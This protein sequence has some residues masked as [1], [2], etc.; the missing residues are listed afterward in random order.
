MGSFQVGTLLMT[1]EI[2]FGA[3]YDRFVP[4]SIRKES[5]LRFE[6]LG[7]GTMTV[8]E[9]EVCFCQLAQHTTIFIPTNVER[10]CQ[11][12]RGLAYSIR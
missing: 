6:S 5:R 9:Y 8:S 4:W 12:V 2:L 1:W 10:V 11:F 3:F 7:Q